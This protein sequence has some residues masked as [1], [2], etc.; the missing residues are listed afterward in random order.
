MISLALH[1]A[2]VALLF[3]IAMFIQYP[4]TRKPVLVAA[5]MVILHYT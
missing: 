4:R 3:C 2:L 5:V 1:Y